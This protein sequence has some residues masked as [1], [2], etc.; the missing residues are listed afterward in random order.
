MKYTPVKRKKEYS[1][2]NIAILHC[3]DKWVWSSALDCDCVDVVVIWTF[4]IGDE[5]DK[6]HLGVG[7]RLMFSIM[8]ISLQEPMYLIS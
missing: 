1:V 5:Q 4:M 8:K 2:G 6:V 3:W 7:Y